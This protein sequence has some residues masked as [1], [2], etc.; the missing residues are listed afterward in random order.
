MATITIRNLEDEVKQA[1]RLSAAR[2]GWSMEEE[3]RNILRRACLVEQ[4]PGLGTKLA[5]RFATL[6]GVELSIPERTPPRYPDERQRLDA[7]E[8]S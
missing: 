5:E 6:G 1:L 7:V 4:Q 2:H 3:A 8:K